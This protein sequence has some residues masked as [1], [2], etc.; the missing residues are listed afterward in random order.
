M[1][2]SDEEEAEVYEAFLELLP[3]GD[4]DL[5][6]LKKLRVPSYNTVEIDLPKGPGNAEA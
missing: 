1:G 6:S 3:M 2:L 4:F 5:E